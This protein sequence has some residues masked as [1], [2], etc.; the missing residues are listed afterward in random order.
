M[1]SVG[2]MLA[3]GTKKGDL[4]KKALD[5]AARAALSCHLV[6]DLGRD[7]CNLFRNPVFK[8]SNVVLDGVLKTKK[9]NGEEPAVEHK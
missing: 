8:Q 3:F 4:Y 2:F 5:L 1:F 6:C 7:D 9:A